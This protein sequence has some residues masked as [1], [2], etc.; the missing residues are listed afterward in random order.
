MTFV[1]IV[2]LQNFPNRDAKDKEG[3]SASI[4]LS[5]SVL[6]R[7][8]GPN[9]ILTANAKK[10]LHQ[11]SIPNTKVLQIIFELFFSKTK[12]VNIGSKLTFIGF[13][14]QQ[15]TEESSWQEKER[16]TNNERPAAA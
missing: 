9:E 6:V 12:T 2:G 15:R 11:I 3:K 13:Y 7:E 14:L 10:Q 4:W 8:G 16:N 1:I 5:D